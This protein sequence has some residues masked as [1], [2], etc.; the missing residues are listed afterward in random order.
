MI[1]KEPDDE[2]SK[3]E[4]AEEVA[5]M[6]SEEFWRATNKT[7]LIEDEEGFEDD[8]RLMESLFDRPEKR[9]QKLL[10]ALD[11]HSSPVNAVRWNG[12]GTLFASAAD[13][14]EIFLW[15]Y[16][17]EMIAGGGLQQL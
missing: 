17:G 15:E 16:V 14:G 11:N 3:M 4:N 13:N 9:N 6:T 1:L 2:D 12:V 10:A 8:L 7:L 5:S